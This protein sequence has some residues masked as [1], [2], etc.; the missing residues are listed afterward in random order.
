MRSALGRARRLVTF[1]LLAL[2]AWY[3]FLRRRVPAVGSPAGRPVTG[4]PGGADVELGAPGELPEEVLATDAGLTEL[5]D[6][7]GETPAV[8][9]P[10]GI[11]VVDE[12]RV[13]A[14]LARGP[15]GEP[16]LVEVVEET[17]TLAEL[18]DLATTTDLP[19]LADGVDLPAV[20]LPA[21]D[22]P[23]ADVPAAAE[24]EGPEAAGVPGWAA[25]GGVPRS[26]ELVGEVAAGDVTGDGPAAPVLGAVPGG[27]EP[28]VQFAPG[29]EDGIEEPTSEIPRPAF[30][31]TPSPAFSE[32]PTMEMP[33]LMDDLRAV[34]GI[35]PSMERMLHGLGIVSFR[36]LA[37]LDGADL[38]RVRHE[39]R[40]FRSRIEREDWIGQ[41][42]Q[43]H[44]GK[45]GTDPV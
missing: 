25:T 4:P 32:A 5:P 15:D 22:V 23:A 40:D 42:R 36:Q 43:L 8:E 34:R 35:G 7:A 1:L 26:V 27:D 6:A 31:E 9:P 20:D 17:V 21:A 18:S 45:Y 29:I 3:L 14:L 12:V 33:V 11:V 10:A 24:A 13:G 38:E 16:E 44:K 2:S 37:L 30:A 28:T 19:D 41:A 39:L